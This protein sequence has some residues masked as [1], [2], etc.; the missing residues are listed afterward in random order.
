[1]S[2]EQAKET[3]AKLEKAIT[4]IHSQ[5]ASSLSFEELY[6]SAY[7]MVLHRHGQMLYSGMEQSL[8][9]HLADVLRGLEQKSGMAFAREVLAKWAAY[10]KSTGMIRDILMVRCPQATSLPLMQQQRG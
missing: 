1:M 8:R 7:N 10:H 9:N 5:N 2:E 3:W 4:M 6:R